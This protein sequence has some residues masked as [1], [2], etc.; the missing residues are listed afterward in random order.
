M[1][2]WVRYESKHMCIVIPLVGLVTVWLKYQIGVAMGEKK[3]WV[4][5]LGY[6]M[7]EEIESFKLSYYGGW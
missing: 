7:K 5:K 6:E 4:A 1:K 2:I 3:L